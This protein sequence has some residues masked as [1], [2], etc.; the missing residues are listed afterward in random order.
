MARKARL[1]GEIWPIRVRGASAAA[2]RKRNTSWADCN[3]RPVLAAWIDAESACYSAVQF[4][5]EGSS[6][7]S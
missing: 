1:A 6:P 4:E 7:G 2:L 5:N 3:A